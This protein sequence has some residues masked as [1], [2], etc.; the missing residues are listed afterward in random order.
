MDISGFV[1]AFDKYQWET[2]MVCLCYNLQGAGNLLPSPA[3]SHF[4]LYG[5]AGNICH[6]FRGLKLRIFKN[7]NIRPFY[8]KYGRAN[9]F[10]TSKGSDE[11]QLADF[12]RIISSD[13]EH[14]PEASDAK[15]LLRVS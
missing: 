2:H 3:H 14:T 1:L 15:G 11:G 13:E 12:F 8:A 10:R 5:H 4:V 6:R 9:Q 7:F